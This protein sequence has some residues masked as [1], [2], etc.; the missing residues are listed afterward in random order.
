MTTPSGPPFP[1]PPAPGGIGSFQIGVGVIGTQPPF[2]AYTTLLAQ[3]ANS[4]IILQLLT[5]FAQY[6]DQT[7][8][9]ELFFEN[10]WDIDTASGIGLDIWGRIVG[11]VRQL[12]VATGQYF[13]FAEANDPVD[14][15]TFNQSPFFS[16][17]SVTQNFTLSD[18]AFRTLIFAKALANISDGS[19]PSINQLLLNLFPNRGNC[20]VQDNGKMSMTYVF[21]FP[22]DPV[23]IA[24]VSSSGVL[25]KSTGVSATVLV[26][27][28]PGPGGGSS[29]G[30]LVFNVPSQS[31]WIPEVL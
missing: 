30:Q 21:E 19:I 4:P 7:A 26:G 13:G 18:D 5:N 25:P 12:S 1:L 9:L 24:I 17:Q 6:L 20:F 14:E 8:N 22:L 10:I 11:V 31:G 23:E 15:G 29:P 2:D 3:Y 28:V 27:N 16:G